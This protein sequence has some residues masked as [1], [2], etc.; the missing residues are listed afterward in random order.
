MQKIVFYILILYSMY[1]FIKKRKY[2][3]FLSLMFFST[4]FYFLPMIF[5]FVT[6]KEN[7]L[8]KYI[9]INDKTYNISIALFLC[10]LLATIFYDKYL[11]SKVNQNNNQ[12]L[13]DKGFIKFSLILFCFISILFYITQG[14]LMVGKVRDI[15]EM[16]GIYKIWSNMILILGGISLVSNYKLGVIVSLCGAFFDLYLGDR[17]IFVILI[18]SIFS[19]ILI[20]NSNRNILSY[21]KI[22][23]ILLIIVS[24]LLVYKKIIGPIQRG[25]LNELMTRVTTLE[26][27]TNSLVSIEPFTTQCILNE[28]VSENYKVK[29]NTLKSIKNLIPFSNKTQYKTFNE[30][31]QKDL[32]PNVTYG[33]GSNIWAEIYS[34]SSI[35]AVYI[36][37]LIYS[38]IGLGST[39]LYRI[40]SKNILKVIILISFSF[41]IFYAHRN[42]LTYQVNLNLRV[43]YLYIGVIFS[44]KIF[45]Y[46]KYISIYIFYNIY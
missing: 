14:Y 28:I 4:L 7:D 25:D 31:M 24:P 21:K 35:N 2:F 18:I 6:I 40:C 15:S 36:G 33:M 29:E 26:T 11:K 17:T 1:I 32:F 46:L 5:G 39:I 20:N 27:Y 37:C 12:I 41:F 3:D 44:Y 34:N 19:Y 16:I 9:S 22:I 43:I 38:F 42:S 10:I 30:Q 8:L 45:K 23:I 13:L